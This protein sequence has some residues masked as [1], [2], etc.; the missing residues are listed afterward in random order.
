MLS[1][2]L[3]KKE[4]VGTVLV[5]FFCICM[6][7]VVYF[8]CVPSC[9]VCVI[10]Y[11]SNKVLRKKI[12]LA[13]KNIIDFMNDSRRNFDNL[14]LGDTRLALVEDSSKSLYFVHRGRTLFASYL[15][16]I[17]YFSYLRDDGEGKVYVYSSQSDEDSMYVS[18]FDIFA[19]HRLVRM[20]LNATSQMIDRFPL[21]FYFKRFRNIHYFIDG[22]KL[23]VE[24]RIIEFCNL[25]NI[26]VELIR[27]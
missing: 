3:N 20:R 16:L 21:F 25:R 15:Y 11:A 22:R 6:L 23:S 10:G 2:N 4:A 13:N 17:H 12:R 18:I 1:W 8:Y 26:K 7:N 19:Y 9:M 27:K 24:D 5:A 14:I